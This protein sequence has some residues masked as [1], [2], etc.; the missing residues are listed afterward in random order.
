MS[1][2]V[3]VGLLALGF[4]VLAVGISILFVMGQWLERRDSR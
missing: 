4:L 3:L 2:L 1:V